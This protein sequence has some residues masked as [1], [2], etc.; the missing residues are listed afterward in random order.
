MS[1]KLSKCPNCFSPEGKVIFTVSGKKIFRCEKCGLVRTL[2]MIKVSYAEYHRD[3]DYIKFENHF[4]N[5]FLK[6]FN[7]I[8][9][10]INSGKILEIGCSTGLLLNIFKANGWDVWG[11]EPSTSALEAENRGIKVFNIFFENARLRENYF[12]LVILNHTL[13]HFGKP[14]ITLKKVH[15]ILKKG[16]MVY[17]EVPNF[18]SL[19]SEILG[20]YWPYILPDEHYYHFTPETLSNL[21]NKA[22][23]K[24][25]YI[26]TRSGIFDYEKPLQ[27]LFEEIIT[28]P[29]SF[30]VDFVTIPGSFFTTLINRGTSLT[31]I[32]EK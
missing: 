28:R 12:D 5:L 32:A 24:V 15:S 26:K 18:G 22:G 3:F 16:G 25:R 17:V 9:K 6:R 4:N 27:G 11:I 7:I 8:T 21:L 23:F 29:K 13:E 1:T 10:Y 19:S 14:V 20:K 30:L 31:I 2:G